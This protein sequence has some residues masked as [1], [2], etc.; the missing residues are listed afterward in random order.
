MLDLRVYGEGD[1]AQ[2]Q[3]HHDDPDHGQRSSTPASK[4][5]GSQL[6]GPDELGHDALGETEAVIASLREQRVGPIQP[7]EL[8]LIGIGESLELARVAVRQQRERM[9]SPALGTEAVRV[10]L[11][12]A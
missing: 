8:D 5:V 6:V 11:D 10:H 2:D 9:R 7:Q 3:C 12:G 4:A 1:A